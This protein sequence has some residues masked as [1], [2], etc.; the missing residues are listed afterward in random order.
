MRNIPTPKELS[1]GYVFGIMY[2]MDMYAE[3]IR[4]NTWE[5]TEGQRVVQAPARI[6]RSI[7][8]DYAAAY[9]ACDV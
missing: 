3:S 8:R 7:A 6:R 4:L 1:L 2:Q 9:C 5:M